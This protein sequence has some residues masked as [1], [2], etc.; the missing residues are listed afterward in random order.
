MVGFV[1]PRWLRVLAVALLPLL[2]LAGTAGSLAGAAPPTPAASASDRLRAAVAAALPPGS[3]RDA[4][5][6][7]RVDVDATGDATV[8]FA[9]RAADTA[10]EIVGGGAADILAIFRAVY[11]PAPVASL[12]TAT[13]IGTYPVI[14]QYGR[15]AMPVMRAVLSRMTANTLGWAHLTPRMLP[16]ALDTWWVY[17]PL[18]AATPVASPS[19]ATPLPHT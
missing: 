12:R 3:G 2:A 5:R 4:S 16:A 9:L 19:P 15:R 13:V 8:V 6:L 1:V 17:P 7:A 11:H 18:L 14:G 10:P